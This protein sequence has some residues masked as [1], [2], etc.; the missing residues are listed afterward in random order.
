M[1]STATPAPDP[2]IE[3]L[4]GALRDVPGVVAIG[5]GGSRSIGTATP[6]SDYDVIVFSEKDGDIDQEAMARAISGLGG[7]PNPERP[8]AELSVGGR[9][10]EIFFR[11]IE[12]IESE[13]ALARKGQFRRTMN[14]LHTIG[15]LST[16]VVSYAT[17]VQ[18][19]WD[20][21]GRL[22]ALIESAF[23]YPEPLRERMLNTFRTEAKLALIHAGK[24]RSVN[25]VAHLMGLYARANAA[26]AVILF[27]ANRRYPV[28]DKGGRQLVAS[29]P[30]VP[31]N[32]DFRSKAIF[33]AAAAGDLRGAHQEANRLHAE[34]CRIAQKSGGAPR[35]R[36][37]PARAPA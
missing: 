24:V 37:A 20:P 3:Q 27:A 8:L 31:D 15:F 16:I 18:P 6:H 19:L 25:D 32:F 9:K 11:T 10:V 30:E 12:R 28:I 21:A 2:V 26:W 7:T 35:Q 1:S 14:P 13:I 5:L 4:L 22:K 33:R 34:V 36:K 23:P 29:F 17:Y